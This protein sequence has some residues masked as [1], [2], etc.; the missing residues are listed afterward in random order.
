MK[1]MKVLFGQRR[2]MVLA[3]LAILVLTAAAL[4]ASS[5][6][7]TATS[8]NPNNTFSAGVMSLGNSEAGAILTAADMIPGDTAPG[9]VTIT[10]VGDAAGRITLDTS[11]LV[12]PAGVNGGS[13]ANALDVVITNTTTGYVVYAGKIN[14]VPANA[15]TKAT[16]AVW[17]AGEVNSFSFVV[18]FPDTGVPGS[19]T[20]GDNAY[21]GANMSIQF[22]WASVQN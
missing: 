9:T 17:A 1:R 7:F 10:N 11:N 5:A 12:S 21:Q 2:I 22:D 3:T 8:A 15:W 20:T 4:V 16:N 6:S 18:T 14:A 19:A 13:L